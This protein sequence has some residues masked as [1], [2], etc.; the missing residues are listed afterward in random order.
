[1][2]KDLVIAFLDG[3]V[4]FLIFNLVGGFVLGYL[5]N[6]PFNIGSAILFGILVLIVDYILR[7][8]AH[9]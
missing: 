6:L 3:L 7:E 9:L 1:M 5:P 2:L 8:V 4:A